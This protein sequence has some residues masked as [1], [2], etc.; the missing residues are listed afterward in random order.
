MEGR[1]ATTLIQQKPTQTT[2][3]IFNATYYAKENPDVLRVLGNDPATL[4]AHFMSNGMAEGRVCSP[5]YNPKE[6]L[7][8]N[9]DVKSVFGNDYKAIYNHFIN[10]GMSEGR[11]ASSLFDVN[12]YKSNYGD[13]KSAFG[14]NTAEYYKHFAQNGYYEGRKGIG[15]NSSTETT[16]GIFN[17]EYYA[18]VNTDVAR[19]LG[20][21]PAVLYKHFVEYGMAEGRACSPV[22]NP[23]EYLAYNPFIN[24]GMNEGRQASSLFNINYYKSSYR[25]LRTAFGNNNVEYYKHFANYGYKEGRKGTK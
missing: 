20:T 5:V 4:Y 15:N 2:D 1:N 13:L 6:Y 25:D 9:P 8:Y 7:E 3:G 22:Y 18:K 17:A 12:F 16:D 24:N 11:K 19:V 21:N 23:K 14:N 10:N